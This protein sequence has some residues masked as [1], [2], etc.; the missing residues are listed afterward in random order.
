LVSSLGFSFLS[1]KGDFAN[2]ILHALLGAGG[3]I[4]KENGVSKK[5]SL[6]EASF[7]VSPV[8]AIGSPSFFLFVCSLRGRFA[9]ADRLRFFLLLPL[10]I[11]LD[12][13]SFNG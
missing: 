6:D 9:T 8:S 10:V 3:G 7:P 2:D 11:F 5:R 1:L 13:F 4:V 12:F